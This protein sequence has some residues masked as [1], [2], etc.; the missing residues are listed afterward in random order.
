MSAGVRL[1]KVVVTAFNQAFHASYPNFDL[2]LR[3]YNRYQ[4][5]VFLDRCVVTSS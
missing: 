3:A 1:G 5:L 4:T 2:L